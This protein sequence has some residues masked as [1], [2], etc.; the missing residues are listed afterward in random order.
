ME[1]KFCLHCLDM[2]VKLEQHSSSYY[3]AVLRWSPPTASNFIISLQLVD[4]VKS[5]RATLTAWSVVNRHN[6]SLFISNLTHKNNYT[7]DLPEDWLLANVTPIFKKG[8]WA[9][10]GNYRPIS[11]TSICC[12]LLEHIFWCS[13]SSAIV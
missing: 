7:G 4:K 10:P 13:G 8:D 5:G 9:D 6:S 2:Y 1:F 3:N 12:K 11:L